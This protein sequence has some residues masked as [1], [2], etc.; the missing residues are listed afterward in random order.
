MSD[1]DYF[2]SLQ[3]T[4][5]ELEM[6]LQIQCEERLILEK[7]IESMKK[8]LNEFETICSGRGSDPM[9]DAIKKWRR[10]KTK[11]SKENIV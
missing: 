9:A 4:N 2:L 10:L 7:R 1:E 11:M 3:A 8:L 5:E 6:E